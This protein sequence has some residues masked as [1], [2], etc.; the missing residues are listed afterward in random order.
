MQMTLDYPLNFDSSIS[1]IQ[2]ALQ[3]TSSSKTEFLLI[4]LKIAKIHHSSL[5]TSHSARNLGFILPSLTKLPSLSLKPA[6]MTFA[7]SQSSQ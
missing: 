1:H 2:N 7:S 3:Q 4:G 6:T 5:D